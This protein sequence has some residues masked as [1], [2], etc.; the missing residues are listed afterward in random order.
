VGIHYF[1]QSSTRLIAQFGFK[2]L[3]KSMPTTNPSVFAFILRFWPEH[4]EI[5][6]AVPV[7]RGV[8]EHVPTG[9]RQYFEKVD[10]LPGILKHYLDFSSTLDNSDKRKPS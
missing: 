9:E 3:E 1:W 2:R 8:I 10:E 4:R 5:D 6:G 7:W